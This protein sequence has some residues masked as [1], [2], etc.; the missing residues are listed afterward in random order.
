MSDFCNLLQKNIYCKPKLMKV[1]TYMLENTLF[2]MVELD[3]AKY[4]AL[5]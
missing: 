2:E 4:E 5:T 1:C 3:L